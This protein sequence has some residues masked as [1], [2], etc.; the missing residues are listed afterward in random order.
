MG[1]LIKN[2]VYDL[3]ASTPCHHRCAMKKSCLL[4]SLLYFLAFFII[5]PSILW[6]T[7][8]EERS[9]VVVEK[10]EI[11]R[12]E[13]CRNPI[14]CFSTALLFL[15]EGDRE[16]GQGLLKQIRLLYPFTTWNGRA[17]YLQG[18]GLLNDG[19]PQA[20]SYLEDAMALS[21]IRDYVLLDLAMTYRLSDQSEDAVNIYNTLLDEYPHS[22]LTE[23]ALFE[24]SMA[25]IEADNCQHAISELKNFTDEYKKS[26]FFPDAMLNMVHCAIK[27]NRKEEIDS[28]IIKLRTFYPILPDEK[29][30]EASKI[31]STISDARLAALAFST[32]ERYERGKAFYRKGMFDKAVASLGPLSNMKDGRTILFAGK[33]LF[34]ARKYNDAVSMLRKL[35]ALKKEGEQVQAI[36]DGYQLLA[37]VGRRTGNKTLL[38]ESQTA[39]DELAPSSHQRGVVLLYRGGDYED[40]KRYE[41]ALNIYKT[42]ALEVENN[43]LVASALWRSAW[44]RY[45]MGK[46]REAM[47]DF[48]SY[49]EKFPEG[50]RYN[51]FLYWRG[52]CEEKLGMRKKAR[53]TYREILERGGASYYNYVAVERLEKISR[54]RKKTR[55]KVESNKV[56]EEGLNKESLSSP[57]VNERG[58]LAAEELLILGLESEAVSELEVL[59]KKYANDESLLINIIGMIYRSGEFHITFRIVQ[60]YFSHIYGGAWKD[61]PSEIKS[62]VFPLPVVNYVESRKRPGSA[63][64]YLVAA[65]MREESA[66][67]PAAVSPAG[68]IGLM[69]IMPETG[70]YL[71][72]KYKKRPYHTD[73]LFD[74]DTSIHLGGLYLGQLNRRFKGDIVYTI[75]SYNAGPTA[76][77]RWV[78]KNRLEKDEFIESM[79]YD[80]TRAYTKRVLRSY[81][82]YL[83]LAGKEVPDFF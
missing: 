44:I 3:N 81:S 41:K 9:F 73:H 55:H 66:F 20:L 35:F 52:R 17:A 27:S 32:E 45:R 15:E 28:S 40:R 19:N 7:Q 64:P 5:S 22:L 43:N 36:L 77:S 56:K 42:I 21:S 29:E 72:R 53:A 25:L 10:E 38:N 71:A 39:L 1:I 51:D 48:A 83:K 12:D 16:K 24:K 47:N 14:S 59:A 63:D 23:R 69:Q 37:R 74:P 4:N 76:V 61:A 34:R 68:A 30:E 8:E 78:K 6:A 54:K 62:L 80:E 60:N 65:I 67:D 33:A 49:A 13:E 46:Y 70:E 18:R 82:Q 50:Y 31:L 79:P 75:A 58:Y 11:K 2:F 26:D 57:I